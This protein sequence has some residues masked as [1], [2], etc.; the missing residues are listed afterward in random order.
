VLRHLLIGLLAASV[1]GGCALGER[2]T[3]SSESL[4][5]GAVTGDPAVD[6]VLERLDRA[7][8]A[9]E[10]Q[11]FTATFDVLRTFGEVANVASVAADADRRSVTV[12]SVRIVTI[13]GETTTCRFEPETTCTGGSDVAQFSDTGITSPDVFGSAAA[14]RL[15]RDATAVVGPPVG[16]TETLAGQRATCVDLPLAAGTAT[17]CALDSGMIADYDDGAVRITLTAYALG[18]DERLMSTATL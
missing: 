15:R 16:R 13:D 2:P 14:R 3:L 11:A 7:D 12:G 1:V 10:N 8:S 9:A 17:Y 18:V 5:Q 4:A 6:A